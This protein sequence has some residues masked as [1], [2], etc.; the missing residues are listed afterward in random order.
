V[1]S[2]I[3]WRRPAVSA[4]G[5]ANSGGRGSG[6][7]RWAWYAAAIILL[8]SPA[9]S[10]STDSVTG[11]GESGNWQPG[12]ASHAIVMGGLNRTFL[13][14][15]PT[16][17]PRGPG[18][19][20]VPYPLVLVLHGSSGD[21]AAVEEASGM[22]S[23]ANANGF[24]VA[25]PDG[26]PGDFDLYPTDWNAGACCG[27][28][29]V[30]DVDDLAFIVALI[31]RVSAK[32]PVD[33]LR[34]YVAGFSDGGRMAYHAACQLSSTIA[35]IG[36]VSGSLVDDACAPT[37]SVALFAVHGTDDP[38]IAYDEPAATAAPGS[39]PSIADS[40]PPA[41]QFWA[42]LNKCAGGSAQAVSEHVSL[43]VF[44]PCAG[45]DVTFYSILGGT[46]GWPGGPDDPG[47]LPP[48]SELKTSALM[49][50][51]FSRHVR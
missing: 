3:Q 32:L 49:W 42:A 46:H 44:R 48:M 38:E 29:A 14:H 43:T 9:V 35:A 26:S 10:C 19:T 37:K 16:H 4:H 36:V 2:E 5:A 33:P 31:Q 22:D 47:D 11:V 13:V 34:V 30:D 24:L 18:S 12:T 23:L 8:I 50:Q 25:Y 51:F 41:V 6:V 20:P 21:G 45:A 39:V 17:L 40:L 7:P 27:A 15:V 1:E 28:A